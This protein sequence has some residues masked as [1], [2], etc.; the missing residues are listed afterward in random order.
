MAP[1][2]GTVSIAALLAEW[3]SIKRL[4]PEQD[5]EV[6]QRAM[7]AF[8]NALEIR[9]PDPES[10]IGGGPM[11]SGRHGVYELPPEWSGALPRTWRTYGTRLV[12][13][14]EAGFSGRYCPRPARVCADTSH[15]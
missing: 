1:V 11:S 13:L 3:N 4:L 7:M 14:N 2:C 10:R 5:R 9:R 6:L 8:R 12:R 15:C